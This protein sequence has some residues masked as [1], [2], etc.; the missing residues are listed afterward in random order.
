MHTHKCIHTCAFPC[1]A[2]AHRTGRNPMDNN[3]VEN[4]L[5]LA[6]AILD[7]TETTYTST[8]LAKAFVQLYNKVIKVEAAV[9]F[10]IQNAAEVL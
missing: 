1:F 9:L 4:G 5:V 7:D 2:C 10:D 6:L 8:T 3:L